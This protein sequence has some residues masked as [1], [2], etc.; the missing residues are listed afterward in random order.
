MK[1]TQGCVFSAKFT[2]IKS[3]TFATATLQ[4]AQVELIW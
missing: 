1:L 3:R 2:I 4:T